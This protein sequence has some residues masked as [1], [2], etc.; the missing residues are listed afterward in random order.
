LT[1]ITTEIEKAQR[2]VKNKNSVYADMIKRANESFAAPAKLHLGE[3]EAVET[4][5]PVPE[6][7]TSETVLPNQ[8]KNLVISEFEIHPTP[9]SAKK[10]Q[11]RNNFGFT[12][13][14]IITVSR[15]KR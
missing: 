15:P 8:T 4:T 7:I 6:V 5:A 12:L 3:P 13:N 1:S 11:R 14:P 2:R 10:T 9:P